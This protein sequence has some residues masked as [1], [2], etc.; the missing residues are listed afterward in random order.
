VLRSNQA[1]LQLLELAIIAE[2]KFAEYFH[3]AAEHSRS[4][5]GKEAFGW[6]AGE[7]ERHAKILNDRRE[8]LTKK[9]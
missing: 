9:L 1:D 5:D 6:L 8:R 4:A 2:E 3:L 7:E